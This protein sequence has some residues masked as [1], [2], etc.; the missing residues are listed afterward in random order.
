MPKFKEMPKKEEETEVYVFKERKVKKEEPEEGGILRKMKDEPR[1]PS[2]DELEPGIG[3]FSESPVRRFRDVVETHEPR[4]KFRLGGELKKE[5]SSPTST[6]PPSSPEKKPDTPPTKLASLVDYSSDGDE[7][8]EGKNSN[9]NDN[10]NNNDE[11]TGTT[12]NEILGKHGYSEGAE[13]GSSSSPNK[14]QRTSEDKERNNNNSSNNFDA[15]FS[16]L[17]AT[18]S[19]TS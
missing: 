4:I 8:G 18:S 14:K 11:A 10:S 19:S 2:K 6:S 1:S 13:N 3:R 15:N 7:E 16:R 5:P 9:S 12:T 17:L